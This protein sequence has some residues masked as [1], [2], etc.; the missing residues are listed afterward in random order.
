MKNAKLQLSIEEIRFNILQGAIPCFEYNMKNY[1]IEKVGK[2]NFSLETD[3]EESKVQYFYSL[4]DLFNYGK[5]EGNDIL[6]VFNEIEFDLS[7]MSTRDKYAG[8]KLAYKKIKIR[9]AAQLI[10]KKKSMILK[11]EEQKFL[12]GKNSKG[13][14]VIQLLPADKYKRTD[15]LRLS[16]LF[17][18][19]IAD[20]KSFYNIWEDVIIQEVFSDEDYVSFI[21]GAISSGK[22]GF[23]TALSNINIAGWKPWQTKAKPPQN[24]K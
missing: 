17:S 1:W 13:Y 8:D 9:E 21:G 11:Y 7:S 18:M 5:L 2:G 4:S 14:S 24:E 15:F 19:H 6:C 3:D 12:I 22:S 20:N 10:K 23:D 16:N